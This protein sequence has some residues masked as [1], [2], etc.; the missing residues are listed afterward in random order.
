MRARMHDTDWF[1][2]V[3]SAGQN[4]VLILGNVT[5]IVLIAQ[6]GDAELCRGNFLAC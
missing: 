2:I 4:C 5:V 3:I 6:I 1:I